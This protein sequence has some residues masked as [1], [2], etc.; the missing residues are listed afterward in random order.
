MPGSESL[1]SQSGRVAFL[2][3]IAAKNAGCRV[4]RQAVSLRRVILTGLIAV[5]A[6]AQKLQNQC[7]AWSLECW[8]LIGW[9]RLPG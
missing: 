4:N 6:R 8:K 3:A 5:I 1:G 2:V 9:H 7:L